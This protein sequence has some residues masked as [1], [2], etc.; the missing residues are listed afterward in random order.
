M[1]TSTFQM[2][3]A[4]NLDFF[5]QI[6]RALSI[7]KQGIQKNVKLCQSISFMLSA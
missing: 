6:T 1:N 5:V 3:T 7:D 4:H 2:Y